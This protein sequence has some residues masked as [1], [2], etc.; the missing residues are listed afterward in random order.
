[1]RM[2]RAVAERVMHG[3]DQRGSEWQHADAIAR[4]AFGEQHHGIAAKQTPGD[5][6]GRGTRLMTRLSGR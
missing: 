4:G 6:A 1:M 5:F 2:M 3:A